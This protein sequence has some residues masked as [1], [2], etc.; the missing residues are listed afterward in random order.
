MEEAMEKNKMFTRE[1][2]G[3]TPGTLPSTR[4]RHLR[5]RLYAPHDVVVFPRQS[6]HAHG[7][8]AT[9]FDLPHTWTRPQNIV[10]ASIV[11]LNQVLNPSQAALR[12]TE[13]RHS[14][15]D[16]EFPAARVHLDP[17]ALLTH[18]MLA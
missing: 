8:K 4:T 1:H 18:T 10:R 16:F 14:V 9:M 17:L 12:I 7:V 11:L 13:Y 15:E 3:H 2:H 5:N 6:N